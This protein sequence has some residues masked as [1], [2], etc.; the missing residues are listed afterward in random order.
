VNGFAVV[1]AFGALW[2]GT[3]LIL[4]EFRWFR[5]VPLV[6]RVRPH[7]PARATAPTGA[8]GGL[9]SVESLRD[10]LVPLAS[11][12]G[13][14]LSKAL[15]LNDE[16]ATRLERVGSTETAADFRL[17][18]FSVAGAAL[19]GVATLSTVAS[20]P[21]VAIIG[22]S[23]GAPIIAYLVVEQQVAAKS[24]AWQ[25][26]VTLELP[27]VIE[28][29]GM[30]LSSGHSLSGAVTRI[31][32]RGRGACAAGFRQVSLRMTQ[33][34]T[35]TEALREFATLA[36]VA[37]VHRLVG[38]LAFNR[39][40]SDLGALIA[41]ESR[42]VRREVHRDLLELIERRGQAVW[43]PVTVAT[44]V[45]GV[46]FMAVPFVDAMRHLTGT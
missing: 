11:G 39:E 30:L 10:L 37:A 35:E 43:I 41:N 8:T 44:L 45:P 15:G 3:L 20:W 33:G 1:G 5:R 42:L 46:I 36:D 4:A 6:E 25:H 19:L 32:Q 40:A 18:Q 24:S 27:V 16:L 34:L 29:L 21:P 26:R 12:L 14:R 23:I 2:T 22:A 31:G 7:V 17:R 13:A 28:Q 9:L 38:V